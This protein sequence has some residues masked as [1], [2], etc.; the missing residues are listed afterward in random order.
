[1]LSKSYFGLP[2]C[3]PE[4]RDV[5]HLGTR[6]MGLFEVVLAIILRRLLATQVASTPH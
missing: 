3:D 4:I 1:M 6:W 5:A 2:A